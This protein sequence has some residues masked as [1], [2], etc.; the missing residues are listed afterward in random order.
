[1]KIPKENVPRIKP[2]LV[3]L[4]PNPILEFGWGTT[5]C[6]IMRLRKMLYKPKPYVFINGFYGLMVIAMCFYKSGKCTVSEEQESLASTCTHFAAIVVLWGVRQ[7][8]S[9]T[10]PRA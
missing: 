1:M 7:V 9:H 8:R 10:G 6:K 4:R 5:H 3:Q 2:M